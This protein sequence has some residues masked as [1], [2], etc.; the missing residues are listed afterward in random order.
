M[1][2]I[3]EEATTK[4]NEKESAEKSEVKSFETK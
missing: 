1:D 4:L 2:A 3:K